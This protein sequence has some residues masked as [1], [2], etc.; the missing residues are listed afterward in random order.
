[1]YQAVIFAFTCT[2]VSVGAGR[3]N[4]YVILIVAALVLIERT[5]TAVGKAFKNRQL[6]SRIG[7]NFV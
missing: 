1:M 5:T 7:L 2:K 6:S 3:P 4:F